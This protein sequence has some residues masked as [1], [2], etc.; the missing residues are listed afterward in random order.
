MQEVFKSEKEPTLKQRNGQKVEMPK[1]CNNWNNTMG[2]LKYIGFQC[3]ATL[4][5]V[6]NDCGSL[7]QRRAD[8]A[9]CIC[10]NTGHRIDL[11]KST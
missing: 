4:Q 3:T 9:N 2:T 5:L 7:R 6:C 8:D 10:C 11:G 1:E